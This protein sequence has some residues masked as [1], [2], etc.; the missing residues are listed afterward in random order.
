MD[1]TS[2]T[3]AT[4]VAVIGGGFT[5]AAA[6]IRL[7]H[8]DRPPSVAVIEPRAVLGAGVAYGTEDPAHRINVPASRMFAIID[9][10]AG[11]VRW[12]AAG[13]WLAAD[14]AATQPDGAIFVARRVFGRYVAETLATAASRPG[15][16][17]QHLQTRAVAVARSTKG[18]TVR[19]ADGRRVQARAVVLAVSHP[20]PLAPAAL[21]P[22]LG[23]PALT[24]DIFASGIP[25][26]DPGDRVLIVGTGLTMADAVATL[27]ARGHA[28]PIT[29]VSR[30]GLLSRGHP[31]ETGGADWPS[32]AKPPATALSLLRAIRRE[33][34]VAAAAGR[35]WQAV[36]DTLRRQ[37]PTLWAAL[38]VAERRHVV[39]RLRPFWDV[40]RFRIA[41][42][43]AAAIER[44]RS[45]G[46]LALRVTALREARPDGAAIAVRFADGAWQSFDRVLLATGPAHGAV[47][48]D[49][50]VLASLHAA[51]LLRPDACALGI[52]VD[53]SSRALDAAGAPVDRLFVAGPLAR[54]RF[55]ELMGLPEV[56]R[57]A[58]AVADAVTASLAEPAELAA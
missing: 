37:G 56:T 28:G 49:N 18:F 41:P 40:H 58:A 8:H 29:A 15:A 31:A 34:A 5:G 51:G 24:P 47:I 54:G 23:H 25:A 6:A 26:G 42:Q 2:D 33:V 14:P 17:L 19:L 32:L 43:P 20:P 50:P 39:A 52:D 57:H 16:R 36:F 9:D 12:L 13:G 48:A 27:A 4:D 11:F 45:T 10:E 3:L 35:P 44:L 46:Q 30:R 53:P 21:R 22:L 1:G 7:L 55:G 38:P